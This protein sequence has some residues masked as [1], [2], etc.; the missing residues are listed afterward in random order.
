VRDVLKMPSRPHDLCILQCLLVP[1]TCIRPATVV[2]NSKSESDL[3]RCLVN[4]LKANAAVTKTP[5]PENVAKLQ[6]A[7]N[8]YH[9]KD[10]NSKR[11]RRA[12]GPLKQLQSL[13][14]RFGG[15]AGRIR[16]NIMGRRINNCGRFVVGPDA[17]LDIWEVRVPQL[18]AMRVTREEIVNRYNIDAMREAVRTGTSGPGG[19][20]FVVMNNGSRAN[21]KNLTP[22]ATE[23]ILQRIE[24]G[25]T[26]HRM[27][28]SKDVFTF[29]RQ[30]TLSKDSM[31]GVDGIVDKHGGRNSGRMSTLLCKPYNADFDGV[32]VCVC[33]PLCAFFSS[34]RRS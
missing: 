8:V 18:V 22:A 11:K 29:N 31:N 17:L 14:E 21:L 2:R 26:V 32:C 34:A 12:V 33:L 30:P 7:V 4:I 9:D 16:K 19:A 13:V 27:M 20:L 23:S 25:C 24:Y 10:P 28:R 6:A 3:T 5:S 1:P 15:K